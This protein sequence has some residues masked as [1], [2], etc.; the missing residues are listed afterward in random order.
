VSVDALVDP[1]VSKAKFDRELAQF[2][3]LEDD[4]RQR[5]WWILRATFPEILVAFVQPKLSPPAVIFGATLDFTNY[6]LWPPS[7]R[8]V[9]PFTKV[10][11]MHAQLPTKLTRRVPLAA[12]PGQPVRPYSFQEL[13]VTHGPDKI[14]FICLP[15]IREYHEHPAHTGDSWL[16]HRGRGA[17]TL[18][19]IL[20]NLHKYGVEPINGYGMS[21][22]IAV[23]GFN[24]GNVP[25]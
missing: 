5:G 20:T 17:G 4:Y 24:V 8:I 22:N 23:T 14:P 3:D 16:L 12:N 13:M 6:D 11:Y 19:F 25:E 1:A 18:N 7:V 9:N 15:G 10:P 2:Y 21:F